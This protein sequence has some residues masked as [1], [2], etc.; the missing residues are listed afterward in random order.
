MNL[1][2]SIRYLGGLQGRLAA[3]VVVAAGAFALL[4]GFF[5]YRWTYEQAIAAGDEAL[6]TL[7]G[8]LER[9]AAIGAYTLD[10]VLLQEIVDGIAANRFV[11]AVEVTGAGKVMARRERATARGGAGKSTRRIL[12]SPFNTSEAVGE[13]RLV[14][15]VAE[16]ERAASRQAWT[17]VGTIVLQ[18]A[19]VAAVVSLAAQRLV[20][21]PIDRVA[22]QLDGI[23]PGSDNRVTV[24][25]GH[26]EDQIGRLVNAV[27]GLLRE[28]REALV[29]E[30]GLRSEVEAM[31]ARYRQIFDSTSAGIFVLDPAG[32]LVNA[33]RTVFRLAGREESALRSRSSEAFL[34][35]VFRH[36]ERVQAMIAQAARRGD[37]VSADLE[38]HPTGSEPH[39]VHCLISSHASVRE[40]PRLAEGVLYDVTERKR[41]E[42]AVRHEAEH[43]A[44]TGLRNRAACEAAIEAWCNAPDEQSGPFTAMFIDLD[45]F[46]AINDSWGHPA[47]DAVLRECARRMKG[48]VRRYTDVVARLGGD[49]FAVLLF[50]LG[51][52]DAM[53]GMLAR[54]VLDDLAAPIDVPGFG[55]AQVGLSIGIACYPLHGGTAQAV[56]HAADEAM[57]HVKRAGKNSFAMALVSR[58]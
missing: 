27:N 20:T 15:D 38:L 47:G 36:P 16:M 6:S 51:P 17:L 58:D 2:R 24:P 31:E 34:R 7:A 32:D 12:Y 10:A 18:I 8:A 49:E 3:V 44:L 5:V 55:T 1:P 37:T 39:W 52:Q 23:A 25:R 41:T 40:G 19:L 48:A 46:K 57:Y 4:S 54:Q 22:R 29:R 9:S 13:L 26:A 50:G 56:I 33:N 14:P 28:Q 43:D 30:R 11:A 35:L 21:R 53:V 45:G 42:R